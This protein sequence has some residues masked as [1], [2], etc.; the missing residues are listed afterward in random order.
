MENKL[1]KNIP[2]ILQFIGSARF[3]ARSLSNIGNNLSSGLHK[4]KLEHDD[5]ICETC[6]VK[7]KY[8]NYFLKYANF[9]DDLI[10]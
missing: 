4:C 5:K 3:M 10:E 2:Y 9:K 1:Q 7:F 8:Y 6:G